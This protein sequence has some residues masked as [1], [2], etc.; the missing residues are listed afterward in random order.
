M[1]EESKVMQEIREKHQHEQEEH[2]FLGL[3]NI[4][5]I[6]FMLGAIAGVIVYV[7][8]D[9][10]VG[11]VIVGIAMLFKIAEFSIRMMGR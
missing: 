2:K 4:L 5:N 3:R 9:N 7:A 8:V 11:I 10:F 1:E 6:I